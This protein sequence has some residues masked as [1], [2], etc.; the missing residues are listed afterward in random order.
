MKRLCLAAAV[1]L[2]IASCN[3]DRIY[4]DRQ[5]L[6]PD[7]V[8]DMNNILEFE[9][10][11]A[12]ASQFYDIML[13]LRTVDYYP[14]SNMWLY[15]NTVAPSGAVRKDTMECI[16]RDEKGFSTSNR[17]NI[18]EVEDY[19]I[20]FKLNP[21]KFQESGRYKFQIQHGMR[22]EKLPFVNEVGLAIYMHHQDQ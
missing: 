3:T 14:T 16:L 19:E 10:D 20:P 8:W 5:S 21:V 11:V 22:M 6:A 15:I 18:G 4:L 1:S 7:M 12:D 2:L 13:E 9:A 17:M